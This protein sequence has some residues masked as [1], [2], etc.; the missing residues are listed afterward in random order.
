MRVA[1]VDTYYPA[2]LTDFHARRPELARRPYRARHEALL[3]EFFGTA[4]AIADALEQSGHAAAPL[5]AND[6][7]LQL[8]WLRE[9]SRALRLAHAATG[10]RPRRLFEGDERLQRALLDQIEEL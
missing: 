10:G 8:A 1:V 5:V 4:G 7:R 9:R 6:E 2:F 3:A